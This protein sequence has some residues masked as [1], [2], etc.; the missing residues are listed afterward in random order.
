MFLDVGD[1]M[2]IRR[3]AF[4]IRAKALVEVSLM[5][6]RLKPG[7]T[8]EEMQGQLGEGTCLLLFRSWGL[9]LFL[10]LSII[11]PRLKSG[12]RRKG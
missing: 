4:R 5:Y 9:K 3:D 10:G 6:P 8:E 11:F 1:S 2:L 12:L 7:V